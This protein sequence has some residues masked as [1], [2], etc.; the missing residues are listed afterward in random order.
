MD[1]IRSLE[2]AIEVEKAGLRNYLEFARNTGDIT[3]KNMFITL[4]RD[5]L[6]HMVILENQ[7]E[8]LR[9]RKGWQRVNIKRS[10]VEKLVPALDSIQKRKGA[11]G[12][13]QVDALEVALDQEKRS[14][15]FY[16]EQ[17]KNVGTEEARKMFEKL[18]EME[19][20]HYKLISSQLDYI[21]QTGFWFDI[22][23]FSLETER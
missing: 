19:K 10:E 20:A 1:E 11:S 13:Q 4:A 16:E 6:E 12:L 7:L 23:E 8:N 14:I 9:D 22:P 3:G 5:E 2:F 17:M 18:V 15:E 21:K